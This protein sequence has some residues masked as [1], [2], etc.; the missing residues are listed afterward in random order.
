[1]SNYNRREIGKALG[2]ATLAAGTVLITYAIGRRL[3]NA[4]AALWGGIALASNLQFCLMARAATPEMLFTF[5]L[6]AS[7]LVYVLA[8]FPRRGEEDRP[9]VRLPREFVIV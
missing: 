8:S 4:R 5:C 3:F 9:P 7:M 6:T 1:M 2:A